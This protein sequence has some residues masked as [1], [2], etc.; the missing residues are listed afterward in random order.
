MEQRL[1]IGL[2]AR[3]GTLLSSRGFILALVAAG[4]ALRLLQYLANRS[5]WLDELRLTLNILERSY[6]GLTSPLDYNQ[7]APIGFSLDLDAPL[8]DAFYFGL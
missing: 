3:A 5:L 7:G 8:R 1:N 2:M 4:I 6:A